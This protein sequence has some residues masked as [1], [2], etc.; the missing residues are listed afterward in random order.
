MDRGVVI[1][2]SNIMSDSEDWNA[3]RLG[4]AVI[5]GCGVSDGGPGQ[6]DFKFETREVNFGWLTDVIFPHDV[7]ASKLPGPSCTLSRLCQHLVGESDGQERPSPI[8]RKCA[9]FLSV[10]LV[11]GVAGRAVARRAPRRKVRAGIGRRRW[12]HGV[13]SIGILSDVSESEC[14]AGMSNVAG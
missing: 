7:P 6:S 13:L 8:T 3:A 12:G 10:S 14:R 9:V 1:I 2:V 11:P 4:F 5:A